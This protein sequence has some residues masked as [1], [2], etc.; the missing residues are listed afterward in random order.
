MSERNTSL[1]VDAQFPEFFR[2]EYK[3]FVKFVS[4][5]YN[6]LDTTYAGDIEQVRDIDL[7]DD[8][9]L[10]HFRN[11]FCPTLP[12]FEYVDLKFFIKHAREFYRSKGTIDSVKFLFK[13]LFNE[14]VDIYY[15]GEYLLK[16]Q[17]GIW[18]QEYFIEVEREAGSLPSS[19][20]NIIIE[21]RQGA[22][23][24][25]ITPTR[26]EDIGDGVTRFFFKPETK[27]QFTVGLAIFIYD[28][29]FQLIFTGR[30]VQQ[31][32]EIQI[33]KPGKYWILGQAFKIQGNK[34]DTI[35]RVTKVDGQGGIAAV[36]ILEHGFKHNLN[37]LSIVQPYKNKPADGLVGY[38]KVLVQFD[39]LVYDH[40]L[41][42]TD[43]ILGC[44]D[45]FSG[46]DQTNDAV[47]EGYVLDGYFGS[48]IAA[49]EQQITEETEGQ[50]NVDITID[51]WLESRAELTFKPN[52]LVKT[53]GRWTTD[54][55]II[56]NE[57]IVLQDNDV[58]QPYQYSI[59][60]NKDIS[61]YRKIIGEVHP[62]GFRLYSTLNKRFDHIES[63]SAY[64]T[65]SYDTLFFQDDVSNLLDR[66][67]TKDIVKLR[68]EQI[69]TPDIISKTVE[70]PKSSDAIIE[71]PGTQ[72]TFDA[73]GY[74][75]SDYIETEYNTTVFD[76][77]HVF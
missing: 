66:V 59:E 65:K 71:D 61:E 42:V 63:Y 75:E 36:E 5:Y 3:L 24:L 70:V 49:Q 54:A 62:A 50:V 40:Q 23:V 22:G 28:V 20:A 74:T 48:I 21:F 58:Y 18:E 45:K 30:I 46:L 19:G 60:T 47:L 41:T 31:A 10:Q 15:P 11:T 27:Y 13:A 57:S 35:C 38:N 32:G 6:Y 37:Q 69:D 9:F 12:D 29:D 76:A 1:K 43:Q 4:E 8:V 34:K 51:Q 77:A 55:G 2:E 16:A 73:L 17:D 52:T 56:S 7:C 33:V 72:T 68:N 44:G 25:N 14:N 26:F 64:R 67:T 53:K 39:P